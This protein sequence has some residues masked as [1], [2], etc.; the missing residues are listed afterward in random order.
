MHSHFRFATMS[1]VL[2]CMLCA[3]ASAQEP[4][5]PRNRLLEAPASR[6]LAVEP[7]L[8][9]STTVLGQAIENRFTGGRFGSPSVPAGRGNRLAL[10]CAFQPHLCAGGNARTGNA[11][12]HKT[13]IQNR[14]S[15]H[16]IRERLAQ[17]KEQ[18]Q[19][20]A[21]ATRRELHRK[22]KVE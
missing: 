7:V 15:V 2:S 21:Q 10:P 8:K 4:P 19:S 20:A 11:R 6:G 13:G 22:R 18:K 16:G 9:T 14:P 12:R 1:A 3:S 17:W 5:I